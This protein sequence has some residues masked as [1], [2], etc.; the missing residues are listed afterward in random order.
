MTVASFSR[1]IRRDTYSI[2]LSCRAE[3]HSMCVCYWCVHLS[4][5]SQTA[6]RLPQYLL[7]F[8]I[9]FETGHQRLWK[10]NCCML[11]QFCAQVCFYV[12]LWV[13]FLC[14]CLRLCA[15]VCA[16][17]WRVHRAES[18]RKKGQQPRK[19][20]RQ[21]KLKFKVWYRKTEMCSE[22]EFPLGNFR[23]QLYYRKR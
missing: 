8:E 2:S 1:N 21:K 17:R 11:D 10:L 16:C 3:V 20:N 7:W 22:R 9:G 18:V 19:N 14:V 12:N 4:L 13:C 6:G 23:K 5:N 15:C